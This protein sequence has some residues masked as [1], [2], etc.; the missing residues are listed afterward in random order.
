MGEIYSQFIL[1]MVGN[2]ASE[3]HRISVSLCIQSEWGKIQTR[4]APT[5]DTFN[6]V[7]TSVFFQV[8][9]NWTWKSDIRSFKNILLQLIWKHAWYGSK[10]N[11]KLHESAFPCINVFCNLIQE[12]RYKEKNLVTFLRLI[13]RRVTCNSL[14]LMKSWEVHF[15]QIY[16]SMPGSK[17]ITE[18]FQN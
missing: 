18:R 15:T 1:S 10:N 7:T 2:Y 12:F 13:Y 4:K 8:I 5:T 16:C 11:K 6:A 14:L 9:M 17:E 3:P